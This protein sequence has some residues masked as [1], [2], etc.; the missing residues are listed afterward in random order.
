MP[1]VNLFRKL[2]SRVANSPSGRKKHGDTSITPEEQKEIVRLLNTARS[3]TTVPAANMLEI[4]YNPKLQEKL[5]QYIKEKGSALF[6]VP[7]NRQHMIGI[8]YFKDFH[9]YKFLFADTCGNGPG[10]VADIIRW[11]I[12]AQKNCFK[13]ENCNPNAI[14]GT[15][16][17]SC[18]NPNS[19]VKN[20][21]WWWQYYPR[22]LMAGAHRVACVKIGAP[23]PNSN[24]PNSFACYVEVLDKNGK[25]TIDR[26]PNDVPY[27]AGPRGSKCPPYAPYVTAAG[28]CTATRPITPARNL[29]STLDMN[30][31]KLASESETTEDCGTCSE[32]CQCQEKTEGAQPTAKLKNKAN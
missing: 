6:E 15:E 7:A 8:D 19:K 20:T 3:T 1:E 4:S 23:G 16:F 28:L 11:R 24:Q 14:Y 5:E 32:P 17:I 12:E 18:F 26:A 13:Y 29:A 21:N 27:I 2:V 9:T 30:N 10:T 25:P 22:I 31:P